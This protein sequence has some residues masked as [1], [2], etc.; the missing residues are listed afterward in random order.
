MHYILLYKN[1]NKGNH[2]FIE[3][4]V[5]RF[6]GFLDSSEFTEFRR[7]SEHMKFR[8]KWLPPIRDTIKIKAQLPDLK[9]I[10]P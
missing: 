3:F 1:S 5:I 7:L 10:C 6:A 8:V 9:D 4:G 2:N